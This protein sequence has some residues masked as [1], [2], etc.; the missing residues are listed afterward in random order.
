MWP[1]QGNRRGG[2]MGE[3]DEVE[4]EVAEVD[5]R[6]AMQESLERRD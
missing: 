4:T 3:I 2:V 5:A 6:T 1:A